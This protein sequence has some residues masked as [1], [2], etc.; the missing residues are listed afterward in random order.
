MSDKKNSK[1]KKL[2][3]LLAGLKGKDQKKQLESVKALRVHGNE[4]VIA[5][6]LDLHMSTDSE[7]IK[8]EIEDILNTAKS[9]TVPGEIVRLL[10]QKEYVPL[11]HM[12]LI[13]IWSSGLDYRDHLK[14]IIEASIQG[15]MMEALECITIIENLDGDLSEEQLFE[16]ILVLKEYLVANKD[17]QSPRIEMLKEILVFLQAR[18]DN[19]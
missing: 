10:G 18:N 11:R 7:A 16:P 15:E 9:A 13:S 14:E 1:N 6:M 17:E 5:P 3:A 12:L 8:R 19:A 4:T 2:V